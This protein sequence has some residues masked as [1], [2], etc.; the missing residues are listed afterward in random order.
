MNTQ[1]MVYIILKPDTLTYEVDS[2]CGKS[3]IKY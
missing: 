3:L 1:A 2:F